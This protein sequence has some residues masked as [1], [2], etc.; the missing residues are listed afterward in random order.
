MFELLIF[1]VVVVA[2]V[3]I[4]DSATYENKVPPGA[5]EDIQRNMFQDPEKLPKNELN[6]L[7]QEI[8]KDINKQRD[9]LKRE[10]LK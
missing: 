5:I 7:Y 1:I 6:D 8:D 2:I 9:K 3:L 10:G 4:L